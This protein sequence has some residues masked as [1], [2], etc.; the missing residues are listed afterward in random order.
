MRHIRLIISAL[1]SVGLVSAVVLALVL[2]TNDGTET[3]GARAAQASFPPFDMT[4]EAAD[5]RGV[6]TYRLTWQ[7]PAEWTQVAVDSSDPARDGTS[8]AVRG[9]LQLFGSQA[10]TVTA[11]TS[12][13][14]YPA[15]WLL[16][17][18]SWVLGRHAEAIETRPTADTIQLEVHGARDCEEVTRAGAAPPGCAQGARNV[19]DRTVYVFD[20]NSGIPIEYRYEVDGL[21]MTSAKALEL[22]VH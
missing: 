7:S 11:P 5:Q 16:G 2:G 18:P 4:Y 12:G 20:R 21:L 8:K 19:P 17:P 6:T 1:A 10:G 9:G 13:D 22:I 3:P 14:T 15:Q